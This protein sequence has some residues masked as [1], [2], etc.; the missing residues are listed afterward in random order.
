MGDGVREAYIYTCCYIWV[1]MEERM[2]VRTMAL[3]VN[4][5]GVVKGYIK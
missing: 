4:W 2:E 3:G 5:D 1:F